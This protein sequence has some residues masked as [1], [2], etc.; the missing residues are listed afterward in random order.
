MGDPE[1]YTTDSYALSF[2]GQ[3]LSNGKKAP[4]YKVLVRDKQLTSRVGAYHS[5]QEL[6]GR[7]Q[8][9]VSANSGVSLAD[10][11]KAIFE[12][13]ALFEKEGITDSDIERIKASWKPPF[14]TR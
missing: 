6:A 9:T 3:L 8:V 13:F 12:G 10:V 4:L 14:T 2:L 5:A 11:E 7:F 1:Q